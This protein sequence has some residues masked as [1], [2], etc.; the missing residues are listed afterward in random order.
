[1][2]R[3]KKEK[4][5]LIPVNYENAPTELK[6][7]EVETGATIYPAGKIYFWADTWLMGKKFKGHYEYIAR[8]N[9]IVLTDDSNP[10]KF[11]RYILTSITKNLER[12]KV[13]F[14]TEHDGYGY[15]MWYNHYRCFKKVPREL[16]EE[17][18]VLGWLE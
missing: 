5:V 12:K 3:P 14:G 2:K 8:E 4:I 15:F 13:N 7:I 1:M 16:R 10:K 11:K 17:L 6:Y 9:K 18:K